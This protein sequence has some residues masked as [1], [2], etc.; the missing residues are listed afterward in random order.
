MKKVAIHE[1]RTE[2]IFMD[3]ADL[4]AIRDLDLSAELR[5][6]RTRDV[7]L[8]GAWTGLRFGDWAELSAAHI[9]GERIRI[10]TTKTGQ[11]VVIPMHPVVNAIVRRYHGQFPRPFSNQKLNAYIKEVVRRVP[12][13]SATCVTTSTKGGQKVSTVTPKWKLVSSHTA[14]RSFASNLYRAGISARTI[15]TITGHRSERAF[16]R[17]ICLDGD[18]HADI[19]AGSD[20]FAPQIAM[21]G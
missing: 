9:D 3:E 10:R 16:L 21:V 17:Y 12:H 7:F 14:R 18:Q 11:A 15:M 5:L 19:I 2:H 8:V 4:N 1:E 6:E 20:L 13:F